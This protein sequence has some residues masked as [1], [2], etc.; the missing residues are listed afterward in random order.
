MGPQFSFKTY[1]FSAP[2]GK[3]YVNTCPI[4]TPSPPNTIIYSGSLTSSGGS[5]HTLPHHTSTIVAR[6]TGTALASTCVENA[7]LSLTAENPLVDIFSEP[8][9]GQSLN[10][11]SLDS[12]PLPTHAASDGFDGMELVHEGHDTGEC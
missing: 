12:S 8:F 7:V 9:E 10:L 2:S 6:T 5:S 1:L 4:K 11:K 3:T